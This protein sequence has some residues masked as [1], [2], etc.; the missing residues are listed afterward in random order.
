VLSAHAGVRSVLLITREDAGGEKQIVAYVVPTDPSLDKRELRRAVREQLPEYMVPGAFTYLHAIPL[1]P[2]G[3]IDKAAL[4]APVPEAAD[5]EGEAAPAG[6]MEAM[7]AE[8]WKEVLD[9]SDID[10]RANFFDLGGHSLLATRIAARLREEL[11]V[12][13][14][15]R[16]V[17]EAPTV[18]ELAD[19][20]LALAVDGVSQDVFSSALDSVKPRSS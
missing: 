1:T 3:K 11:G 20:V 12:D 2:N 18:V 16:V 8:I 7:V 4:P 13:I 14:P 19:R 17:F 15:V 10:I 9:L 6:S 5:P